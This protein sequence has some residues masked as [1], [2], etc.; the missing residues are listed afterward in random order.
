MRC[1]LSLLIAV[2]VPLHAG[3]LHPPVIDL[4]R[5]LQ[6]SALKIAAEGSV[7]ISGN[8]QVGDDAIVR[9]KVTTS[10]GTTSE[11]QS[12]V[13]GK[14]FSL[15]YPQ[16]FSGAPA[17]TPMVLYVDA[18]DAAEF[19]GSVE[20]QAEVTLVVVGGKI[21]GLPDLP[22]IFTDDF[23]D[24][25]GNKDQNSTQFPRNRVL[26]NLFLQSRGARLMHLQR[27]GF[28]L[29]KSEDFG[30]FKENA[31][32]YDFDH[33][34]R[35]WA[36]PLGNRVARGFW[37]AVWNTWF[38]AS[39]D[40]PWDGNA[41]NRDPKNFRP[42]T[43][44]NDSA[45][46]VVMHQMLREAKPV[47]ADNR[48]KLVQE[49]ME[50]VLA[51]QHRRPENFALKESSGKQEFYTA[52]AFRYGM[53]ET[54]EWLTEGRGW[55][56]NP[57]FRDFQYGGVLNGRCLWAMGETLKAEPQGPLAARIREAIPLT[58]RFCLH[59]GLEHHYTRLTKSG[60]PLWGYPGEHA[61]LLLGMLAAAEVAPDLS[62][63]LAPEKPAKPLQEVC[64]AA[65]D[66]LVET[67]LPD[68]TW[69]H[70]ANVDATN[71]AALAEGARVFPMAANS[72]K[73]KAAAVRAAD[74][75]LALKFL[76]SE[77]TAPTPLIGY[78]KDAGMTNFLGQEKHAHIALYING[79]WLHAMACLHHVT[80]DPRYLE[81]A[82]AI[83][84]Y[85]CGANPLHVR[86]LNELGSVNNRLTDSDGAGIEDQIGWDAYPEST[87][88]LQI[89]LLRL[90]NP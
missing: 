90:L 12:R 10:L 51:M 40:H 88:F 18:T 60:L 84:A 73:W 50:N 86:L 58:L 71:I 31:S 83:L 63:M 66:A 59:D 33:R 80:Q 54:G 13:I 24:S 35:D 61:Y 52:G 70:Y 21:E 30:W 38:N 43:F 1:C 29:Q 78:R 76:P 23:I 20:H 25:D 69:I 85:F 39:N 77:R 27:P 28:D 6:P 22:Q 41:A 79:L 47:V 19:D 89:G 82:Q 67:T 26:V 87:A 44:A 55:F 81:R 9:V 11:A 45:D 62:V 15:R 48:Q 8:A 34:D 74:L 68:G 36:Q 53:F 17:L 56:A 7:K 64:Q 75:W 3:A 42:Y 72:A 57:E 46:L 32:L 37:Q 4:G 49:V 16:D 65:L 14:E 2:A 5:T